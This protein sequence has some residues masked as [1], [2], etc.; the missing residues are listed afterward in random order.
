M[1]GQTRAR[2]DRVQLRKEW[3]KRAA[4]A[5]ERMFSEA[6]AEALI[7]FT[8]REQC[9]VAISKELGNFLLEHHVAADPLVRPAAAMEAR[10]PKCGQPGRRVTAAKA[11]LPERRL[12]TEVGEV[13]LEREQWRCATCRVAFFPA[14]PEIERGHGGV[15]STSAPEG[16]ASGS[17]G[18]VS[19]SQ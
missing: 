18:F 14:R 1:D 11:R 16:R 3:L 7:T 17:E 19:R 10:C 12:T 2:Q 15:Q 5:F 13:A 6:P 9:A 4:A 8:Q